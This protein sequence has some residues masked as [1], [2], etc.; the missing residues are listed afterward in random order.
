MGGSVKTMNDSD[1]PLI[2][3]RHRAINT[4]RS[5]LIIAAFFLAVSGALADE[6]SLLSAIQQNV[7]W[8]RNPLPGKW[9]T[10]SADPMVLSQKETDPVFGFTPKRIII[11]CRSSTVYEAEVVYMQSGYNMNEWKKSTPEEKQAYNTAF[12]Q[13]KADLPKALEQITGTP[14]QATTLT[15]N[16]WNYSFNVTDYPYKGLVLRL[17]VEDKKSICLMIGKPEDSP[18]NLLVMPSADARRTALAQNVVRN[19]NGDVLITHLP[20]ID[21][22]GRP[23]CGP[24]C[25][26]EVARYYGLNVFQEMM[27][28][29]KREGG[30]GIDGAAA[31]TKDWETT[32]DFTKIQKS[33]DAGNPI[34][35]DESGHVALVT[36]YNAAQN[37]IFRTDSW[38]EGS[39]NKRVPVD[40]FVS[41][42][43]GFIYFIP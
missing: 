17:Y 1:K 28:S 33:I 41:H 6:S 40:K 16:G 31:L 2:T 25:W 4:G 39:R 32:F 26:T 5:F 23:D 7:D 20:V 3:Q 34:W 22:D 36:G 10:V 35:F 13:L 38:G 19:P 42:A 14:G 21:Q 12:D 9:K 37:Q 18:T 8:L 24:A 29:N 43:K 30:K 27:M 15:A 11:F